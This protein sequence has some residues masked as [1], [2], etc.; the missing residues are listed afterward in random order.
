MRVHAVARPSHRTCFEVC[1]CLATPPAPA[2][3]ARLHG[4]RP[5]RLQTWPGDSL[6]GQAEARPGRQTSRL[7][8]TPQDTGGPPPP[9]LLA[10]PP[11]V[12]PL[13]HRPLAHETRTRTIALP[14]RHASC[15]TATTMA[16]I[17]LTMPTP[18]WHRTVACGWPAPCP[19]LPTSTPRPSP[20]WTPSPWPWAHPRL[21]PWTMGP[22]APPLARP[23][24]RGTG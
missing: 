24:Q 22:A 12:D 3:P 13:R 1:G 2:R 11:V 15:T 4:R 9:A 14:P 8:P 17:I 20:P 5:P 21:A 7:P 10:L 18:P 6:S 23:W 19:T 16:G